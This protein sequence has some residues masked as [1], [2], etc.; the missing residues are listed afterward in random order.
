MAVKVW[1]PG[2]AGHMSEETGVLRTWDDD[3]NVVSYEL[4]ASGALLLWA[5]KPDRLEVTETYGPGAWIKVTGD[6]RS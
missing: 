1:L 4:H 3:Q 6:R 2:A 5:R